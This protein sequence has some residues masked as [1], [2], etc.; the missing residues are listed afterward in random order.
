MQAIDESRLLTFEGEQF[1]FKRL[2]FLRFRAN[3]LQVTLPPRKPPRKTLKEIQRLLNEA[4]ETRSQIVHANLRLVTSIARRIAPTPDDFDE[5]VAEANTILVNAIDKFDFSRGYRFSTYATHAI[6]RHLYRYINR[7]GKRRQRETASQDSIIAAEQPAD[8]ED[9]P[10]HVGLGHSN[11][12]REETPG[13]HIVDGGTRQGQRAE[14]G[15]R[16][17]LDVRQAVAIR[18]AK[19]E[20]GGREREGR[21]LIG[22]DGVVGRG[23]RRIRRWSDQA[24]I[25]PI[26]MIG[27]FAIPGVGNDQSKFVDA[28]DTDVD[29]LRRRGRRHHSTVKQ[30]RAV[31]PDFEGHQGSRK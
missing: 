16:G 28:R 18:V 25:R 8:R 31:G 23:G 5:F 14:R 22:R 4:E 30:Q 3:A 10:V 6:Q 15:Q 1:L 13:R 11:H 26:G 2:N 17:D 24:S 21:I 27:V 20:V 29:I 19:G 9:G 12:E 7:A